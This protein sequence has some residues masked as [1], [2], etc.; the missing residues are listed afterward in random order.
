MEITCERLVLGEFPVLTQDEHLARYR[1]ATQFVEGKLVADIAC[2]TG[3]GTQMLSKAGALRVSGMDS[4]E[5]TVALCRERYDKSPGVTYSVADAQGLTA[6]LDGEYEVV[7]SFETIEHLP[8]AEAY[9]NEMARI[10]K[11]GGTLLVSTPDRRLSS[12]MHVFLGHPSNPYHVRE[13]TEPEL[14]V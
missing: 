13:Y 5:Q 14:L 2:G 12:V 11:P 3:Y 4:S 8:D 10:L 1:F 6:I 9:L 7:V